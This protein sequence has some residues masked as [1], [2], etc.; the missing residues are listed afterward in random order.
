MGGNR[1]FWGRQGHPG[2]G[3]DRSHAEGRGSAP[4]RSPRQSWGATWA[5]AGQVP[6]QQLLPRAVG[7]LAAG[8]SLSQWFSRCGPWTS[9]L[10]IT[11]KPAQNS[12]CQPHPRPVESEPWGGASDLCIN[13]LLQGVRSG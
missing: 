13:K 6:L 12:D 2:A 5:S 7:L 9:I 4:P 11:R 3:K 8:V 10:S 1:C